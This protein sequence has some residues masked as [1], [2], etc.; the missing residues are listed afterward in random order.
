QLMSVGDKYRFFVP[1]RLAYGDHGT[2]DGSIGPNEALIFDVE[3]LD[4][5]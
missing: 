5:K 2:P 3:L 1:P 4:V